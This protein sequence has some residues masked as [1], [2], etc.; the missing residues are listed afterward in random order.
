MLRPR[1]VPCYSQARFLFLSGDFQ[2]CP[3][4][5]EKILT[6]SFFSVI[7]R[8]LFTLL[9]LLLIVIVWQWQW[10]VY[11]ARMGAGQ[12]KIIWNARPVEEFL[13]DPNFP[14]SLKTKLYLIEE[15][16]RYAVDSLGLKDTKNYKTLYD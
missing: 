9:F 1:T 5:N 12:F 3:A 6:L 4:F 11:G 16:R 14:D 13:N 15:V 7:K 2:V 8:I 10:I